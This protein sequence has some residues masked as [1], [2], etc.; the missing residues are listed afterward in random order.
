MTSGEPALDDFLPG[1][2]NK[3]GIRIHAPEDFAG[4]RAAGRLAADILD[5]IAPEVVPGVSTLELDAAVPT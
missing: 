2:L 5:R 3:D 1:R 4:M